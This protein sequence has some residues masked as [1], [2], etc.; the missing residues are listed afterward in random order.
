ML[1]QRKGNKL[2]GSRSKL[3][4]LLQ[5]TSTHIDSLRLFYGHD[6]VVTVKPTGEERESNP[7]LEVIA[8]LSHPCDIY[9]LLDGAFDASI[10]EAANGLSQY[11]E[12]DQLPPVLHIS[13]ERGQMNRTKCEE[14]LK[15]PEHIYMDRYMASAEMLEKRRTAWQLKANL[16]EVATRK[17][18]LTKTEVDLE[19]PQALTSTTE[20]L[21]QVSENAEDLGLDPSLVDLELL[22]A[23]GKSAEVSRRELEE[24]EI[25]ISRY[26]QQLDN[27]FA[28]D[29]QLPYRL[30]AVFMHRSG[31]ARIDGGHWFIYIYD[32]KTTL[33]RRYN[34]ETISKIVDPKPFLDPVK[35]RAREE[36]TSSFVVYVREDLADQLVQTVHREPEAEMQESGH[37]EVRQEMG[38]PNI[39]VSEWDNA[40]TSN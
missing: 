28:E 38:P 40:D 18:T 6:Q 8:Y 23:I 5:V 3:F 26:Q 4:H 7:F 20:Y 17:M 34:D 30:H 9:S 1:R 22:D 12:I 24:I 39:E 32:T 31:Q 33:W 25:D 36:G 13:V 15:L 11:R 35:E 19:I 27:I 16:L 37:T 14:P 29:R 10:I 21:Q 2:I